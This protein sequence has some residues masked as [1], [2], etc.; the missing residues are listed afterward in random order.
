ML[1]EVWDEPELL[2]A[3]DDLAGALGGE[4]SEAAVQPLRDFVMGRRAEIERELAEPEIPWTLG[5]KPLRTCRL[6]H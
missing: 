3:I 1:D 5:E 2:G 6:K 4:V